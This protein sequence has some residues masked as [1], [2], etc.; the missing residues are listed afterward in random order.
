MKQLLAHLCLSPPP[1]PLV[2]SP[3]CTHPQAAQMHGAHKCSLCHFSLSDGSTPQALVCSLQFSPERYLLEPF[4]HQNGENFP[5]IHTRTA[6]HCSDTAIIS[7]GL[8]TD[9]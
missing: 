8:L 4:L 6:L 3:A 7:L 1:Q 5:L 2:H 9:I